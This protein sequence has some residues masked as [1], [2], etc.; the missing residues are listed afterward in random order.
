MAEDKSMKNPLPSLFP[1]ILLAV[2]VLVSCGR[3]DS[4]SSLSLPS[5]PAISTADRF[6]VIVDPYVSL[7]DEPGASGITV[8]HCRK[9]EIFEVSGKRIVE[10][11][12]KNE[13]WV[14]LGGGWIAQSSVVLFSSRG[15]AL[16]ASKEF[17]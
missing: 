14:Y 1:A 6:A 15:R 12:G 9:G 4:L 10:T 13:V 2:S 11:D 16:T 8:S 17:Q 7:R 3:V 5:T